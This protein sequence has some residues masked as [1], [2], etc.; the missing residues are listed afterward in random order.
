MGAA[1]ALAEKISALQTLNYLRQQAQVDAWK[2]STVLSLVPDVEPE[3]DA[4]RLT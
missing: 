4:D 2:I 1:V 3:H